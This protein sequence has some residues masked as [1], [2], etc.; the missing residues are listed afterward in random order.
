MGLL[1]AGHQAQ[2]LLAFRGAETFRFHLLYFHKIVTKIANSF[3]LCA[4]NVGKDALGGGAATTND[5]AA[6]AAVV[7]TPHYGK[8]LTTDHATSGVLVGD[9]DGR[10]AGLVNAL[11]VLAGGFLVLAGTLPVDALA[12]I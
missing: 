9:P 8:E 4:V 3:G 6:V 1:G 12:E 11:L 7:T 2:W 5:F 10:R